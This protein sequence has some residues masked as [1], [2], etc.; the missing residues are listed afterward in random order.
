LI[1]IA[2]YALVLFFSLSAQAEQLPLALVYYGPGVCNGCP[3]SLA[4]T[5]RKSGFKI[6][7][8]WA[9]DLT[10]DLLSKASIFAVPGGDEEADVKNALSSAEVDN[11]RNFVNNGGSYLGVCLG[12]YLATNW[13]GNDPTKPGLQL[14]D[15]KIYN[16]S[17]TQEARMED[18]TWRGEHR[19]L[20]FQDGPEFVPSP[21]SK[22][23]VWA[24]YKTGAV[25]ALQQKFGLG[26]VGLIG[27]HLEADQ[28]WL[29]DDH[30]VDPDGFDDYLM[31]AFL[32]N[33][34]SP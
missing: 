29:D 27:P 4:K 20:Y 12:A 26:H 17:P 2:S 8:V 14:F 1:K 9:G 16:H 10:A 32:K 7:K 30:L 25:A 24:Y 5:I 3:Q 11:I 13:I 6:Q 15:G 33:L 31:N 19:W 34:S 18:V 22:T 23:D 28:S 21:D